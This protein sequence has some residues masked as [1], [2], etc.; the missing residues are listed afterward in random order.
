MVTKRQA[1]AIKKRAPPKKVT[2]PTKRRAT[3]TNTRANVNRRLMSVGQHVADTLFPKGSSIP[4]SHPDGQNIDHL[5]VNILTTGTF[6]TPIGGSAPE[7][8][9]PAVPI[10]NWNEANH[11]A[12]NAVPDQ[13][14]RQNA[15][16]STIYVFTPGNL[17]YSYFPNV[18]VTEASCTADIQ[19]INSLQDGKP[20]A[21]YDSIVANA[22]TYR[23]IGANLKLHYIGNDDDNNGEII[24][25]KFDPLEMDYSNNLADVSVPLTVNE[26]CKSTKFIPAKEGCEVAFFPAHRDG[27]STYK[28]IL[29]N[30]PNG[31]LD[32]MRSLEGIVLRVQGA[33]SANSTAQS[34][35]WELV[36]T[37]ELSPKPNTLLSRLAHPSP[38]N[39]PTLRAITDS[40]AKHCSDKGHD[41]S[42]GHANPRM[43][44]LNTA[45]SMAPRVAAQLGSSLPSSGR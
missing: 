23:V 2:R 41:I 15:L 19:V 29:G 8:L 27:F 34:W 20:S 14:C 18:G 31:T 38:T 17:Q 21:I 1:A 25:Q 39:N 11:A 45:M 13:T 28:Q 26:H 36:Q 42:S 16:G 22:D 24:V 10:V 33:A 44:C 30:A 5:V 43:Q 6:R 9:S 37:V 35:R 7:S 40:V 12:N 32:A 3:A 4:R